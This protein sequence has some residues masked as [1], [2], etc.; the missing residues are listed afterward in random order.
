[1]PR[2]VTAP[3]RVPHSPHTISS[4]TISRVATNTSRV[5]PTLCHI[6]GA[7]G[8]TARGGGPAGAGRR[9]GVLGFSGGHRA[10]RGAGAAWA[11]GAP[12]QRPQ[13]AGRSGGGHRGGPS[14]PNP[15]SS[16]A[17]ERGPEAGRRTPL[18]PHR[19][20]EPGTRRQETP[21]AAGCASMAAAERPRTG[22]GRA[23]AHA[24]ATRPWSTP[25]LGALGPGEPQVPTSCGGSA[26]PDLQPLR[27]LISDHPHRSPP[28]LRGGRW[29]MV[30][31][32][33]RRLV[34]AAGRGLQLPECIATQPLGFPLPLDP[35]ALVFLKP[36]P[37]STAAWYAAQSDFNRYSTYKVVLFKDMIDEKGTKGRQ[38]SGKLVVVYQAGLSTGLNQAPLLGTMD[39]YLGL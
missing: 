26:A 18:P 17:D 2:G 5:S 10:R 30:C 16:P 21:A 4:R 8:Q 19:S 9:A 3:R 24:A 22:E 20:G 15:L 37:V 32:A 39:G 34:E 27:Q 23:Q 28:P 1:M 12:R 33:R 38:L 11:A 7:G 14:R 35:A 25:A 13:G 31:R 6:L 36:Q 29:E